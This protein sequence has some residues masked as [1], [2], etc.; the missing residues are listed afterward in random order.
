MEKRN[1][2][3]LSLFLLKCLSLAYILTAVLLALL[4]L[5]VY[6]FSLSEKLVNLVIIVIYVG[7]TFFGGW[8][9]GKRLQRRKFLWGLLV[10]SLYFLVLAI[11]SLIAD[12]SIQDVAPNFL[13]VLAL[14][15]AGG[16]L[17][18]MFS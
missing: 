16:T 13:S 2:L 5:F 11:I 4:A 1:H 15:A 7:T 8:L 18:G 6:R 9:A 12:H 14:C 3:E 17:G 10:G